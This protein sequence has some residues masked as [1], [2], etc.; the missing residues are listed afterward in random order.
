MAEKPSASTDDHRTLRTRSP[1][2]GSPLSWTYYTC[3]SDR[4]IQFGRKGIV[5]SWFA[6]IL[7][8]ATNVWHVGYVRYYTR[9]VPP[10]RPVLSFLTKSLFPQW[11]S[12][13]RRVY[14]HSAYVTA[15]LRQSGE[16]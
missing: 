9:Q 15:V 12:A 7:L 10:R 13:I 4:L 5:V 6:V 8:H 2:G 16:T 3:R 14:R 1:E 11:N